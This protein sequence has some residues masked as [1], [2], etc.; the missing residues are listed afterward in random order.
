MKQR[1]LP[2]FDRLLKH[3]GPQ[4]W[5]P[6]DTPFEVMV[7]AVLT[8]N[9]S[10]T[11][12]EKAIANLKQHRLLDPESICTA[13]PAAL[14]RHLKPVGYFNVKAL[15]LRNFCRWYV[16]QGG[17]RRLSRWSTAALRRA[18]LSVNG[19]GRE[20]ADDILLYAFNRDVFVIDAYTRRIFSRLGLAGGDEDYDNL[21]LSIEENIKRERAS[22]AGAADERRARIRLYNEFHA[23]IVNHAKDFCRPRPRCAQCCLSSR[24]PGAAE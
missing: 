21:R 4:G 15:R 24:C 8:Q 18:L 3:H 10:W 12:V 17:Y 9:T 22:R 11:N 1:L 5:W 14:A 16:E 6:G 19:V 20:T 7:G 13:A 23:L 2:V